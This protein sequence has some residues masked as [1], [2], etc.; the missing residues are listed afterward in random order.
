MAEI[1][2]KKLSPTIPKR[3]QS[4]WKCKAPSILMTGSF[5]SI[6]YSFYSRSKTS[7]NF[8]IEGFIDPQNSPCL[9]Q[10]SLHLD[11]FHHWIV[12]IFGNRLLLYSLETGK[13]HFM[14]FLL[15]NNGLVCLFKLLDCFLLLAFERSELLLNLWQVMPCV[16]DIKGKGCTV[17]W[18]NLRKCILFGWMEDFF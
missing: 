7:K 2:Q 8:S 13:C 4:I 11:I 10:N 5:F 15:L 18:L 9:V 3:L 14:D 17:K 6:L 12:F 16:V 1:C